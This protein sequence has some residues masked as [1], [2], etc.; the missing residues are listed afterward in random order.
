MIAYARIVETHKEAASAGMMNKMQNKVYSC[1]ADHCRDWRETKNGKY[2]PSDHSPG[3]VNYKLIKLHCLK[4]N[5]DWLID[6]PKNIKEIVKDFDNAFE[7]I[8]YTVEE[9]YL[10][11][12]QFDK[13]P[14]AKGF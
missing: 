6:I 7:D 10:T 1:C 12:D 11:Q 2:P 8:D 4:I 13:L 9:I 3:C 14:E 5:K